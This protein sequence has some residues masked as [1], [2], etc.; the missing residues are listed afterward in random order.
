MALTVVKAPKAQKKLP[1]DQTDTPRVTYK[2]GESV[3]LITCDTLRKTY[4]AWLME[5]ESSY[6]KLA[7][8]ESPM[9]LYD[10]VEK[11]AKKGTTK[12]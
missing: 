12:K 9:P 5:G 2:I 10:Y 3:F 7:T 6:T 11:L 8:A 4:V 1:A